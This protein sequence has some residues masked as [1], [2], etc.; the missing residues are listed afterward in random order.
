[1]LSIKLG[2]TIVLIVIVFICGCTAK[3][4]KLAPF[5]TDVYLNGTYTHPDIVTMVDTLILN[6]SSGKRNIPIKAY[7]KRSDTGIVGKS[8]VIINPGYGGKS[9][10]YGYI[11]DT[12]AK[13]GYFVI[14][15]QHDLP[16]DNPLPLNGDIYKLRKPFWD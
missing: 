4:Q 11:A 6:D 16:T 8:M 15:I 14:T 5:N 12:L 2:R 7:W 13:E 1:M 3:K 9:T 10:D